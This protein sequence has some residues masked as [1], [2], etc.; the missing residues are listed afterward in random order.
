MELESI[1]EDDKHVDMADVF[2][3]NVARVLGD[4]EGARAWYESALSKNKNNLEAVSQLRLL[5]MRSSKKQSWWQ[6]PLRSSGARLVRGVPC[7][8]DTGS[9]IYIM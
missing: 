5:N 2:L 1:A 9:I 6:R 7:L 4:T 3:G 8:A